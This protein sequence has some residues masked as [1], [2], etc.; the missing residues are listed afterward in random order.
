MLADEGFDACH[1][2]VC[3]PLKAVTRAAAVRCLLLVMRKGQEPHAAA[4]LNKMLEQLVRR[5]RAHHQRSEQGC[6]AA[7]AVQPLDR[8]TLR[9][10]ARVS[11]A[12]TAGCEVP[13]WLCRLRRAAAMAYRK[14][15]SF[16]CQLDGRRLSRCCCLPYAP[17]CTEA[18][19]SVQGRAQALGAQEHFWRLS[20]AAHLE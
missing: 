2:K 6:H 5:A 10:A 11:H 7:V 4:V 12:R 14:R 18:F 19:R 8:I 1:S 13:A 3:W 15:T 20:I 9:T 16:G 17:C